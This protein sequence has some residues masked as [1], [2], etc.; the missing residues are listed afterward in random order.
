MP[1]LGLLLG[2]VNFTDIKIP[3]REAVLDANGKVLEASINLGIGNFLQ[4]LVD[5]SILAFAIFLAIKGI[6]SL[7]RKELPAESAPSLT[8]DQTL[9]TEIR[10]ALKQK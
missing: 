5:F 9:L 3:L 1:P 6:N 8:L 7:K 10:D 2:N 4:T